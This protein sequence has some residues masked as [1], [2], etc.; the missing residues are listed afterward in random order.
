VPTLVC[1]LKAHGE[2]TGGACE[3]I[4]IRG[5]SI[6][7]IERV[8]VALRA[9]GWTGAVSNVLIY[10]FLWDLAKSLEVG[11]DR[12]EGDINTQPMLPTHRTRSIWC[13]KKVQQLLLSM[14][15]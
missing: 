15:L 9:D 2:F 8:A 12:I 6:I 3:E 11:E 14:I 13:R 1:A 4:A 7:T 10:F 5:V